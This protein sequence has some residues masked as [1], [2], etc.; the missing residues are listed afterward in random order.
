MYICCMNKAKSKKGP[1]RTRYLFHLLEKIGDNIYI[2]GVDA[3]KGVYSS[4]KAYNKNRKKPL[5]I[6]MNIE[7]D[8]IRVW[9]I[10]SSEKK[11]LAK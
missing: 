6:T 9:K 10:S 11:I 2:K 8:G 4:L 5:C 3:R 1:K 7:G